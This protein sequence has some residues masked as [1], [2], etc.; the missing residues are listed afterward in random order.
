MLKILH[1]K[2]QHYV[3]QEIP[4]SQ[5]RFQKGRGTRG[6]IASI[7]WIIEKQGNFNKTSICFINFAKAFDCVEHD[8]LW[9][10]LRGMGIPN[11]LSCLLRN[12]YAG[13]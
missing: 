12:L 6:Q 9:R 13:H 7:C 1:A 4:D 11:H 10:A 8:K 5:A 2:F 3:N